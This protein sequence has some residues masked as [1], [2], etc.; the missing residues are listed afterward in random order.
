M[1]G[2][3]KQGTVGYQF[4]SSMSWKFE[5]GKYLKYKLSQRQKSL[6]SK[7]IIAYLQNAKGTPKRSLRTR[8]VF[9]NMS[10]NKK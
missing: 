5:L 9:N 6:F 7:E 2:W 10:R 1:N 8:I 4:M 3:K